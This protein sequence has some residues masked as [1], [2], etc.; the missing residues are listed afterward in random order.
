MCSRERHIL[1][2]S[3]KKCKEI[4]IFIKA[5]TLKYFANYILNLSKTKY[6]AL[7]L[8]V[9]WNKLVDKQ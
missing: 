4:S 3:N 6:H 5:S 2:L 1:L 7:D 9:S 8:G